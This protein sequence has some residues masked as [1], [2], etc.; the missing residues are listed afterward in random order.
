MDMGS[1]IES[2][3]NDLVDE[4]PSASCCS[5]FKGFDPDVLYRCSTC[6][7]K[8]EN[9]GQLANLPIHYHCESCITS[10]LRRKHEIV[11]CKG[12]SPA[13]CD[14][15]EKLCAMYCSECNT[16]L[17]HSCVMDHSGHS[18]QTLDTKSSEVRKNIFQYLNNIEEKSKPLKH[19]ETVSEDSSKRVGDFRSSLSEENL[20][21][22][23]KSLYNGVIE[24]NLSSWIEFVD[25]IKKRE[26]PEMTDED[27]TKISSSD[28]SIVASSH[29]GSNDLSNASADEKFRTL[30]QSEVFRDHIREVTEGVEKS[31]ESLKKMLLM[32]EGNCITNFKGNE[33]VIKA[34]V[35]NCDEEL[36]KHACLEWSAEVDDII[37]NSISDALRSFKLC[38]IQSIRVETVKHYKKVPFGAA[39]T[40]IDSLNLSDS[41]ATHTLGKDY[42]YLSPV[43]SSSI[44]KETC[45]LRVL[46]KENNKSSSTL[47]EAIYFPSEVTF[48]L[49]EIEN[50]AVVALCTKSHLLLFFCLKSHTVIEQRQLEASSFPVGFCQ[51]FNKSFRL[52][53][54]NSEEKILL[55]EKEEIQMESKLRP[56]FI[57]RSCNRLH[58]VDSSNNIVIY[59]TIAKTEI[60]IK[61]FHHGFSSMDNILIENREKMLL[62]DYKMKL[63]LVCSI[64]LSSD[65]KNFA[66]LKLIKFDL[67]ALSTVE[68][69]SCNFS[70]KSLIVY[71]DS[72]IFKFKYEA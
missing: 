58:L 60:H 55:A 43:L 35:G 66:V 63:V 32:S 61:H 57:K 51:L 31:T 26:M 49:S 8:S 24:S 50:S 71:T 16:V 45:L 9:E 53:L 54:W 18:F 40:K 6:N 56:K 44:E 30:I 46:K 22:T 10:H 34:S 19:L 15:H 25:Q 12:Y 3:D 1:E 27:A 52:D 29:G 28:V 65:Q 21:E 5:C 4:T 68:R 47:L 41:S 11:D 70:S 7:N 42:Q 48:A 64:S 38:L 72:S 20:V 67:P 13:T 33:T 37:R 59:D 17:C 69:F 36:G 23:L 62:W 2:F 14:T 39:V